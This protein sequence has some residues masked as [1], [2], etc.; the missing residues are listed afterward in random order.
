M[1][2]HTYI[3]LYLYLSHKPSSTWIHVL[4]GGS[5]GILTY[6]LTSDCTYSKSDHVYQA[7]SWQTFLVNIFDI[8]PYIY[9]YC[10]YMYVQYTLYIQVEIKGTPMKNYNGKCCSL[11]LIVYIIYT[12]PSIASGL[13][14]YLVKK[15]KYHSGDAKNPYIFIWG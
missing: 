1:S 10:T 2:I 6:F 11:C 13:Q 14:K 7:F 5:I 9:V 15:I 8:L 4:Q 12:K 3:C